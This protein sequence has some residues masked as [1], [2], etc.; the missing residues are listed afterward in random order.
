M[1]G[2]ARERNTAEG[3]AIDRVL[4]YHRIFENLVGIAD[5]L[6]NV[7]PGEPPAFIK[8]EKVTQIARLVPVVLLGRV[9]FDLGHPVDQL[10]SVAVDVIDDRINHDF[11]GQDRTDP[12]VGA[13][14]E[15]RLASR[16]SAPG[17]DA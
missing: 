11:A 8:R 12:H 1:C 2:V 16:N 15:D 6:R 3:P 9:A 13:A 4:V 10:G 5:H 17:I 7:E 14:P